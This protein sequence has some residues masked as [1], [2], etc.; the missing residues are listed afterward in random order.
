MVGEEFM[1]I[2]QHEKTPQLQVHSELLLGHLSLIRKKHLIQ[3]CV[4]TLTAGHAKWGR[5]F[6]SDDFP[7]ENRWR[8]RFQSLIFGGVESR[9]LKNVTA[10]WLTLPPHSDRCDCETPPLQSWGRKIHDSNKHLH[11]SPQL[12]PHTQQRK[13]YRL[14]VPWWQVT[15][16]MTYFWV[17]RSFFKPK[18]LLIW[19]KFPGDIR[20]PFSWGCFFL[21]VKHQT[22]VLE[23]ICFV[24]TFH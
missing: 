9:R 7:C 8:F 3:H 14:H 10:W 19:Q 1:W 21:G 17:D 5:G 12:C 20:R 22:T 11:S 6:G 15:L 13:G 24:G 4:A 2:V 23:P 16:F 18:F